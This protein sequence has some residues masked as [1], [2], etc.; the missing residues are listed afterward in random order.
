MIV[1][2]NAAV[3]MRDGV[4]LR[5]DIYRPD[6]RRR[7]PAVLGRTPYDRTFGP[8]PPAILD[9]DRAVESG[10]ALVCMDVRGQH[11]SDGEFYPFRA[12]RADG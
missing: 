9:P 6:A 1:E 12:E 10:I 11:G 3:P 5:A 7:V 2:R 8:T 4:L